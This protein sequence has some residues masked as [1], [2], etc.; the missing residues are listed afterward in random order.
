MKFLK[1][2]LAMV[3]LSALPAQAALAWERVTT[4]SVTDISVTPNG[5]IYGIGLDQAV[6]RTRAG[7][8]WTRVT[9]GSVTRISVTPNGDIYGIGLDHAVWRE[10]PH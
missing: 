2:V 8:S 7:G 10:S 5:N 6:W 3:A 4:G 1:F 9:T